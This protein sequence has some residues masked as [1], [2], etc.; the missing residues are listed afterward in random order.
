MDWARYDLTDT[1][2]ESKD[3]FYH[4]FDKWLIMQPG[5]TYGDVMV[6]EVEKFGDN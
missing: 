3:K 6:K 2:K 4:D 5:L 1:E